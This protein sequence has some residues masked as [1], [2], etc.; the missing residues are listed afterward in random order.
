MPKWGLTVEQRE[1]RP[2]GLPADLIGPGKTITDPVHGDIYL[3]RLETQVVNSP[4]MQRLRRVRQLGT[5]YIVYPGATHT[6]FSHSLGALRVAQDILDQVLDQRNGPDPAA[7]I[8]SEWAADPG[9]YA[10]K[11]AEV[12]VMARLGALLHDLCHVPYGHSVEDELKILKPHDENTVRF[13]ALWGGLPAEVREAL[14]KDGLTAALRPMIMSKVHDTNAPPSR[15][16]SEYAFVEDIVGNTI[17]A[18]LLDYLA[19]DHMFTGL[20]ARLGTRVLAGFYVTPNN[21]VHSPARMAMR[22]TRRGRLRDDVVSELFKYLRYRYE[23]S[24]RALA[25]HAK[26]GADAMVGKMLQLWREIEWLNAAGVSDSSESAARARFN[27]EGRSGEVDA[28]DEKIGQIF[29]QLFVRYSDDGLLERLRDS[30]ETGGPKWEAVAHLVTGLIERKLFKP[31]GVSRDARPQATQIAR[32]Y[33]DPA[34]R[35]DLE[36]AAARFLG[37]PGHWIVLWVPPPKMRMKAADVLVDNDGSLSTLYQLDSTL[38]NR[39]EEIYKSHEALWALS[40]YVDPSLRKDQQKCDVL[41]SFLSKEIGIKWDH[42][43]GKTIDAL[44]ADEVATTLDLRQSEKE[45]L[46]IPHAAYKGGDTYAEIVSQKTSIAKL[47]D[48]PAE[49]LLLQ[50][51][52]ESTKSTRKRK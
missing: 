51:T 27:A 35:R 50:L 13:E 31:V 10:R 4:P 30:A 16:P 14:D 18:D 24:E 46:A 38:R 11:V 49:P 43:P 8:I 41:L 48:A 36:E 19:R 45:E 23:L 17:C 3:T 25:H 7:D 39:G 5:T 34:R 29:E 47:R 28:I 9:T 44:A 20:P 22:I 40:V 6:R 12:T 15:T 32:K 52:E 2:W 42:W 1:S 33:S 21:H 26:I 37:V